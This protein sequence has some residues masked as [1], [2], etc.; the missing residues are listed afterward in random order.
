MEIYVNR[1]NLQLCNS[2]LLGIVGI[3]PHMVESNK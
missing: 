2:L 3:F 1:D